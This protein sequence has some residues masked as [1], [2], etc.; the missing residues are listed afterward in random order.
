LQAWFLIIFKTEN[1]HWLALPYVVLLS[2][3]HRDCAGA[4]SM[5]LPFFARA[6]TQ[7]RTDACIMRDMDSIMGAPKPA[8]LSQTT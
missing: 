8:R 7:A 1:K 6:R 5:S 3:I 4:L 2:L